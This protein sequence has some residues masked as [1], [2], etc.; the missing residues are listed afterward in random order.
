MRQ[1]YGR[2]IA[3]KTKIPGIFVLILAPKEKVP[4]KLFL[5]EWLNI[6]LIIGSEMNS[7]PIL[8]VDKVDT[9]YSQYFAKA[10]P[11]RVR[12]SLRY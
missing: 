2:R 11:L 6:D 8:S 10:K 3:P 5:L 7:E 1:E 12:T 4:A 9:K